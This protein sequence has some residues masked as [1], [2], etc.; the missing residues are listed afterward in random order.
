MGDTGTSGPVRLTDP[1]CLTTGV[2]G[3]GTPRDIKILDFW[4]LKK[5]YF[6]RSGYV[7]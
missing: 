3:L 1:R 6:S 7:G 4:T 5:L 2:S